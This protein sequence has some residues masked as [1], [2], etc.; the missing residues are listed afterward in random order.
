MGELIHFQTAGWVYPVMYLVAFSTGTGFIIFQSYRN[1]WPLRSILI[2]LS[3]TILASVI[4]S[5]VVMIPIDDLLHSFLNFEL[6]GH[7]GK[8]EV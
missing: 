8:S 5:K 4:G 7:S 3:C 1:N 6:P 2:L